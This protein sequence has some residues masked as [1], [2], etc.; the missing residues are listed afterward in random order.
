MFDENDAIK[1]I[2]KALSPEVSALYDDD[3][4]FLNVIDMVWDFYELNGMLDID[5]EDDDPDEVTLR[6]D[7]VD[8]VKKTIRKDKGAHIRPQDIE[9]IVGAIL[10][11]EAEEEANSLLD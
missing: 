2:R 3:D 7:I 11:Y 9:G 10:D 5:D 4:E 1:Y 8:Y 6:A